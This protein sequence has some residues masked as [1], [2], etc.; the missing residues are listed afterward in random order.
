MET[1]QLIMHRISKKVFVVKEKSVFQ[2][3]YT[4]VPLGKT[5]VVFIFPAQLQFYEVLWN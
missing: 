3:Y 5:D 2:N 1:N 4:I